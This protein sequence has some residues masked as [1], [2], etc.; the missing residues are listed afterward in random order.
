MRCAEA[1]G[2]GYMANSIT[3]AGLAGR[4][5][6]QLYGPNGVSVYRHAR[7][8]VRLHQKKYQITRLI[9]ISGYTG[10]L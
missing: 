3:E 9:R 2:S 4:E 5:R 6:A 1:N 7:S 8:R 10:T